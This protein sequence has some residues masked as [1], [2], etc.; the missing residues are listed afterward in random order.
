MR[1]KLNE[2]KAAQIGLV[3]VLVV[4]AA[5][6]FLKSSGGGESESSEAPAE[7][8][9]TVESGGETLSV[10]APT[11][12]AAAPTGMGELPT[13]L[14]AAKP[15]PRRFT[16]AYESGNAIALLVVHNGGIDDAYTKLA[17]R[18][19]AKV[20]DL[21]RSKGWNSVAPLSVI[22]V[23]AKRISDYAAVTVGLNVNQVPA[24][25]VMRPKGLSHGIPQATVSYGVQSPESIL[26]TLVDASYDG[27]E[28][29]TYHPG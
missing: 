26:T 22:V 20:A 25:I 23:P 5:V 6:M 18:E 12:T 29:G 11:P 15:L 17:L 16:N 1:D 2:S 13:S 14:P 10:S 21:A 19:A 27:P 28:S 4:V 24:L 3:A 7:T 8:T 9:V